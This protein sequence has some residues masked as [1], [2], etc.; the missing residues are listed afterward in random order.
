VNKLRLITC[1]IVIVL[2]AARQVG[3]QTTGAHNPAANEYSEGSIPR[4]GFR[5]YY[6]L[7]GHGQPILLLS[8]GPGD[9]CDYLMPVAQMVGTTGRAILVELRGTGRSI[10]PQIDS[11]TVS[12]PNILDDLEAL[13]VHLG[14]SRWTVLG[15]SAGAALALY[16]AA[17]HPD[18]V[19]KLILVD[20]APIAS[21]FLDAVD[22]NIRSRL[23]PDELARVDSLTAANAPTDSITLVQLP[24]F[25]FD[26]HI[27]AA[28]ADA[29]RRGELGQD[30]HE[31][32]RL[33]A[34][35][36]FNG[37]DLRPRLKTFSRP[38]LILNGRQDPVG[39]ARTAYETHLALRAS[40]LVFIN[41]A[42]H[43]PWMEQ[44]TEFANALTTFLRPREH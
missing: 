11:T 10:P 27:A 42:G 21:R 30:H 22:D 26:R 12:L 32:G 9:D 1:A 24:A 20:G 7:L 3:A 5:L 41:R 6:R 36:M 13:R 33:L 23:T 18:R 40:T 29:F 2:P 28:A 8:G 35:Q 19:D 15:H 44:P 43:F 25:F 39:D 38:V 34:P 14:A 16:Y 17:A 37:M 4:D 31:I